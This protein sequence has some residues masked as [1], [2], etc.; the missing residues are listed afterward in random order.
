MKQ[1]PLSAG[2]P[3]AFYLAFLANFLFFSSMHLLITPL[4]LYIEKIGG[5]AS[6][7]GLAMGSFAIASIITRPYMGRLAD[8][9]GRKPTLLVGAIMFIL[10]P[11]SYIV[12]R[13]VP[14]LLAA[15][16]FHGI[17]IAAFTSAYFALIADVTP[18][19]RRGE[20][21]G[22]GGVA[23]FVSMIV[24]SPLGTSLIGRVSF[25]VIFL[26][27]ALAALS[28]LIIVI[29]LQ[30]PEKAS[31]APDPERRDEGGLLQ[32]ARL[33]GVW[34]GSLATL[35]VGLT[36]GATYSF[37]PLFA[38]DRGLGNVGFFF[39][40]S[41]IVIMLTRFILGRISDKIGRVPVILPMFVVLAIS[42]TGLNWTYGFF[43]LLLMAFMNGL[44]FGGT[45]VGLDTLVV[46]SAPT[47]ATGAALGILFTCFDTG[48]GVGSVAT[49]IFA[50]LTGYGNMYLLLAVICIFT[51]VAFGAVMRREACYVKLPL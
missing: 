20:A 39:T 3:L 29:L 51:T 19:A 21:L 32:V 5:Q 25:P 44:G 22:V 40:V 1:E 8:T 12:A 34:A 18:A 31:V 46:D 27:A 37:L 11:L 47:G 9:W 28:S 24:A 17:G 45:R 7:V 2:Y 35:A 43:M 4:P 33:R 13:S 26:G 49:G 50:S 48:I 38:R 41:G 6:E 15:R 14:L 30:E 36:Y 23:P 42:M 16:M 10:G